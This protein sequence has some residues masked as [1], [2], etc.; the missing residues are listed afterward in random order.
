MSQGVGGCHLVAV[1]WG[2]QYDSSSSLIYYRFFF[3]L[4]IYP[5]DFAF[6]WLPG[7]LRSYEKHLVAGY[8]L[9]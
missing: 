8:D 1:Y 6:L 3:L 4:L 9:M 7:L 5:S 2:Q